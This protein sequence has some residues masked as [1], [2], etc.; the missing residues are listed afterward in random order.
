MGIGEKEPGT[1]VALYADLSDVVVCAN[2]LQALRVAVEEKMEVI[3][4]TPG[5]SLRE[6]MEGKKG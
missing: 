2:E 3:F 1:W 6:Q 4:A 5:V